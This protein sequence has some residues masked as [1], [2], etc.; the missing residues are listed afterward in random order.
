VDFPGLQ[1]QGKQVSTSRS[2][3]FWGSGFQGKE[4]SSQARRCRSRHFRPAVSCEGFECLVFPVATDY[5]FSVLIMN[6]TSFRCSGLDAMIRY[7]EISMK[8]ET[9]HHFQST[10]FANA[11]YCQEKADLE[12]VHTKLQDSLKFLKQNPRLP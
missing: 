10:V 11:S 4:K 6:V 5:I 9:L 8:F 2:L 1:T 12:A 3:K 7:W